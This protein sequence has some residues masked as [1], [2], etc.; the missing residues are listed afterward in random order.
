[1]NTGITRTNSIDA[2]LVFKRFKSVMPSNSYNGEFDFQKIKKNEPVYYVVLKYTDDGIFISLSDIKT[3]KVAPEVKYEKV[4]LE[5]LK[6]R[7]AVLN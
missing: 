7:L 6:E 4:T 3:D 1:M 5:E 2:K